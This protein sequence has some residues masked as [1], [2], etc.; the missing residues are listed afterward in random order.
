MASKNVTPPDPFEDFNP[1]FLSEMNL[2]ETPY[3]EEKPT[4]SGQPHSREAE[5][6]VVG[7][8]LINPNVYYDLETI[9]SARDFYIH[10][11]R[12]IWESYIRLHQRNEPIDILTVGEE[13][14]DMGRLD[15]IGGQAY[16]TALLNQVPTTLHAEAY[17]RIVKAASVRREI[18]R[19]ANQMA[20]LAYDP[21]KG[22]EEIL[23]EIESLNNA[24][25]D[26]GVSK[27]IPAEVAAV[28]LM[29][30]MQEVR[31]DPY[32]LSIPIYLD[33]TNEQNVL[34]RAIGG[35]PR[36]QVILVYGDSSVGKT[37]LVL[38]IAEQTAL[39]G[40]KVLYI[41]LESDAE[42]MVGRRV[43]GD[44]EIDG[45]F[46]RTGGLTDEKM[47]VV[48]DGIRSY[49]EKFGGNLEFNEEAWS[50]ADLVTA[51]HQSNPDLLI[52]DY[53]GEMSG[54]FGSREEEHR[55]LV[56]NLRGIKRIAKK[57]NIPAIVLHA[58]TDEAIKELNARKTDDVAPKLEGTL[59]GARMLRFIMDIGIL[60]VNSVEDKNAY[61]AKIFAWAMKDRGSGIFKKSNLLYYKRKQT[62]RSGPQL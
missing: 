11:L 62:F 18:L 2:S 46:A 32:S 8:V 47:D 38:Q 43:F 36:K 29:V 61:P 6:A 23:G 15:E 13:L 45:K 55:I 37:A 3:G 16:L 1:K 35:L 10:R 40:R 30:R 57:K 7:S 9:L 22:M 27:N 51:V 48:E 25:L 31:D 21:E 41:T 24:A 58:I 33:E 20:T 39:R 19:R 4:T 42:T 34:Q 49:I 60:L 59:A 14:D 53:L 26:I 52:V 54:D 12:F 28:G 5:E 50:L 56:K 17:G 44:A